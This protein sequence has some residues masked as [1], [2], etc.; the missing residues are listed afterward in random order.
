MLQSG[1]FCLDMDNQSV[2]KSYQNLPTKNASSLGMGRNL[3]IA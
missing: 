3:E 2:I 1:K